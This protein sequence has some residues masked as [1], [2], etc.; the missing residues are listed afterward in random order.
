[1]SQYL[2]SALLSLLL[3]SFVAPMAEQALGRKQV[4]KRGALLMLKKL[5]RSLRRGL[6]PLVCAGGLLASSS[7]SASTIYDWF[8]DS[9][10]TGSSG[11]LEFGPPILDPANFTGQ[12]PIAGAFVF[13]P[14]GQTYD[15]FA[16][17]DPFTA[18]SFLSDWDASLG[19]VTAGSGSNIADLGLTEFHVSEAEVAC[20]D[21]DINTCD[22]TSGTDASGT[23]RL[24][25]VPE[26]AS[27]LLL[28]SGLVALNIARRKR[29]TKAMHRTTV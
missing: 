5:R 12:T 26:P 25:P 19:V 20:L 16:L 18:I 9:V 2:R 13:S 29:G 1:M 3:L 17:P 11:F 21:L 10:S 4:P 27:A 24:R 7:L 22:G 8:P 23:W 6:A 14:T 28:L 15:F